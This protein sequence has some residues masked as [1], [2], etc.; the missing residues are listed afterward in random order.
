MDK[1]RYSMTLFF[2]NDKIFVKDFVICLITLL[3]AHIDHWCSC[4]AFFRYAFFTL[5]FSVTQKAIL[6]WPVQELAGSV[7]SWL[8]KALDAP[9]SSLAE[10]KLPIKRVIQSL[11]KWAGRFALV[12]VRH[13]LTHKNV[14]VPS[15][16]SKIYSGFFRA[17]LSSAS[18][19][20]NKW[21][22]RRTQRARSRDT[23][24][25]NI[26]PRSTTL[27]L[28]RWRLPSACPTGV[29]WCYW[30]FLP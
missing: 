3:Q 26:L 25:N 10:R 8:P 12:D 15:S 29:N 20:T 14:A 18:S 5:Y 9:G 23:G 19:Y 17:V 27:W 24:S 6:H 21:W 13:A 2:F 30:L 4:F 22:E 11:L 16:P 7:F 28:L 1:W